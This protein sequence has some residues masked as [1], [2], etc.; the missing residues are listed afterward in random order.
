MKW[1]FFLLIPM[2][3]FGQVVKLKDSTVNKLTVKLYQDGKLIKTI[4]I[5][6]TPNV[7]FE[8]DDADAGTYEAELIYVSRGKKVIDKRTVRI[9]EIWDNKK[10]K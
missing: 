3:T 8:I 4:W 1:L 6:K 2:L 7:E 10:K 9:G 5:Y